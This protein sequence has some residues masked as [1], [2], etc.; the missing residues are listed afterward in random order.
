MEIELKYRIPTPE[1]ADDIWNDK[2]FFSYEE[3]G[4]REELCFMAKYFDTSD[5]DLAKHSIAYRVR[6]EGCRWVAALKWSGQSDGA[7]HTREEINV[8]VQDDRPDPS[9]FRESE[10]GAVLEEIIGDKALIG[11]LETRFIRRRFRIDTGKGIFELS[12]DQGKIVT[13]YGD[14]PISEVEIELFSGESEELECLGRKLCGKYHLEKESRSKYSRGI[15]I[16]KDN[17]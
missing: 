13:P 11:L 12:I 17:R 16:I 9:V 10:M 14:E 3:D 8:P 6:K 15:R 1:V 2:L 7:L 4:S 5:C